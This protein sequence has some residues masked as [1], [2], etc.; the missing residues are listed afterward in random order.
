VADDIRERAEG[1]RVPILTTR[2]YS[3]VLEMLL[4][5]DPRYVF[6]PGNSPLAQQAQFS[7]DDEDIPFYDPDAVRVVR[8]GNFAEIGRYERPRG[9]SVLVLSQRR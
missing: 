2:S 3:Q 4:G 5:P 8:D 1:P 9:G 6:V 7:L